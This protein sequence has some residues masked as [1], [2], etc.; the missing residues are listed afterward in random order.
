MMVET[1]KCIDFPSVEHGLSPSRAQ[2][3]MRFHTSQ[4]LG[5]GNLTLSRRS[6]RHHGHDNSVRH[7][8]LDLEPDFTGLEAC[9]ELR[10][11]AG[12]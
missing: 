8:D 1:Y 12:A 3:F 5:L 4:S 2:T 11:M 7:A 9:A 10:Y 6:G